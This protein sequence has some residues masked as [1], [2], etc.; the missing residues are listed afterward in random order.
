MGVALAQHRRRW[1]KQGQHCWHAGGCLLAVF[2]HMWTLLSKNML[3]TLL[4]AER[5]TEANDEALN[6]HEDDWWGEKCREMHAKE[7]RLA[8][9]LVA[10]GIS[11][12]RG[13][14]GLVASSRLQAVRP[15]TCWSKGPLC[16]ALVCG[17]FSCHAGAR[18]LHEF[19]PPSINSAA[20][21]P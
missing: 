16:F 3:R 5:Q 18:C 20:M 8:T 2:C 7:R 17:W 6:Q 14:E 4:V 19:L 9:G 1:A 12:R 10:A 21:P 15:L 11:G 13:G